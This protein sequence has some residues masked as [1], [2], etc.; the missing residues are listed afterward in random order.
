MK[1]THTPQIDKRGGFTII[2]I[3][4][5][6]VI[7]AILAGLLLGAIQ[8]VRVRM[9]IAEVKAD[10]DKLSAGI[11][12]FQTRFGVRPPSSI[13]LHEAPAGWAADPKS[14]GALKRIWQNF[15]FSVTRELD[16][17]ASTTSASVTLDGSECLVFF[18]GGV[19]DLDA[20]GN[21]SGAYIGFSKDPSNP[22]KRDTSAT[23][24]RDGPYYEFPGAFNS[25]VSPPAPFAGGRLVDTDGDNYLELL[26]TLPSQQQPM[27]YFNNSG[28]GYSNNDSGKVN[29]YYRDAAGRNPYKAESFQ[30]IS[31]GFDGSYGT[32]GQFETNNSD[33]L[34][35]ADSDNITNFHGGQLKD[36]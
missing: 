28:S 17:D 22:L 11:T 34:G 33:A 21:G 26:D 10:M 31:P 6:V 14:R 19:V 12:N 27:V 4:I 24:S 15:D 29:P 9:R 16:G 5:A 2:E 1:A 23:T 30:I 7:I 20:A 25:S 13:T 18:L 3:M 8:N 36:G 35:A 32:G